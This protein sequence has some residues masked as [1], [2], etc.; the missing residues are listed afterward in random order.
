[1]IQNFYIGNM[2]IT[3][4]YFIKKVLFKKKDLFE[5]QA[6]VLQGDTLAPYL[7]AIVIDYCMRKAISGD[8]ERLGFTL[9][10]RKSRRV[11]SKIS[12]M[13]TSPII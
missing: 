9:Q 3:V 13:L 11:G 4:F 5:I 12:R 10:Q 2:C 8:E 6:V 7:F 1:M